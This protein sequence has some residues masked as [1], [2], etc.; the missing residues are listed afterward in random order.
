[1]CIDWR[2]QAENLEKGKNEAG[3]KIEVCKARIICLA[4]IRYCV[5]SCVLERQTRPTC[6][7][8]MQLDLS[9]RLSNHHWL[10]H[11][12]GTRAHMHIYRISSIWPCSKYSKCLFWIDASELLAKSSEFRSLFARL[13]SGLTKMYRI[14]PKPCRSRKLCQP[15]I[16]TGHIW[17]VE[18]ALPC[19]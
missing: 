16:T 9:D 1:M 2:R 8:D 18:I 11:L 14:A 17:R 10:T 19:S 6:H 7:V 13:V 4:I 12:P 3:A 15:T 5:S